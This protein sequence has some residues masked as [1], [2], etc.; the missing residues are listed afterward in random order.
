MLFN[1]GSTK[2]HHFFPLKD[3]K[4]NEIKYPVMLGSHCGSADECETKNKN[5]KNTGSIPS[6]GNFKRVYKK[7]NRTDYWPWTWTS[8]CNKRLVDTMR[9]AS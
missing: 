9:S 2:M 1:E 6:L 7:R 3:V 5:K 8:D 4:F